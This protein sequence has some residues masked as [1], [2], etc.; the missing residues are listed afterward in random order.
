MQGAAETLRE[1]EKYAWVRYW[2]GAKEY[3]EKKFLCING[4]L[5]GQRLSTGQLVEKE[6]DRRAYRSIKNGPRAGYTRYNNATSGPES[7]IWV[8]FGV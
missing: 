4:P 8:W 5:E 2:G 7:M 1:T 3:K 6:L